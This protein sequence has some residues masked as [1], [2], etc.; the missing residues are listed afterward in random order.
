M[1]RFFRII[2]IQDAGSMELESCRGLRHLYNLKRKL[3]N[4]FEI[5]DSCRKFMD[6]YLSLGHMNP[7]LCQGRFFIPH[8]TIVKAV[9]SKWFLMPR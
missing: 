3:I 7:A 1:T 6:K 2:H 9:R 5:Y 4:D 8:H